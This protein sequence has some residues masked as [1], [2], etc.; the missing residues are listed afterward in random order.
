LVSAK[1]SQEKVV[2]LTISLPQRQTYTWAIG[3]TKAQ[4]LGGNE[5]SYFFCRTEGFFH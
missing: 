2:N 3:T 1:R 5:Q 4:R